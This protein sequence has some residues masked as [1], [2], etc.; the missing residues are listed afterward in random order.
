MRL[1]G[2]ER[3]W[4]RHNLILGILARVANAETP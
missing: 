4:V 2:L 1:A 3:D